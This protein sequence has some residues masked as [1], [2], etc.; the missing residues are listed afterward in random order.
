MTGQD[1]ERDKS[2]SKEM[3]EEREGG[4]N[5]RR[6]GEAGAW[7]RIYVQY[8]EGRNDRSFLRRGLFVQYA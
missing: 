8:K 5:W 2:M 6:G 7:R 1:D 4:E 3:T